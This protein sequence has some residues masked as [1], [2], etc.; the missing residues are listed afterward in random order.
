[1]TDFCNAP[2]LTPVDVALEQLLLKVTPAQETE[3]IALVDACD[4]VLSQDI[5]S[6]VNIPSFDNSAMDG[7]A[8]RSA[9][10]I[11][12]QVLDLVGKVF[13]GH[14]IDQLINQGQCVRIMTGGKIPQGC[15][16]VVM[17]ENTQSL[18]DKIVFTKLPEVGENIRR[19]GEDIKQGQIVLSKGCVLTP[20]DVGLLASLGVVKVEVYKTI[21][22]ALISTGDELQALGEPLQKGQFYESN[23]YTVAALLKRFGVHVFNLGIVKDDLNA[24]RKAFLLADEKADVVITSGGVSVGEADYTKTVIEELGHIDFWKL[25]I[26]PGK[27]FAFGRLPNSYII[28]L[29][30]NPVSALVTLHQ[31]AIPMLRKIS[32]Q[33]TKPALRLHA[34]TSG[35]LRKRPGRMDFQRG[36]FYQNENGSLEV[37]ATGGQGSGILSSMSQAN[38]YIVLAQEAG[39]V[40]AGE[41]VII[42]PFD[43]L[44]K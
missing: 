33:D 29:P 34:V 35:P 12:S 5:K 21:T 13:A 32:G 1:M 18:G 4:R 3:L 8:L 43:E 39:N 30:G 26:K 24:L 31:L 37:K 20:A 9:D 17:Q 6:D 10:L 11:E 41:S 19:A 44:L 36:I 40:A 23:G 22:V 25:A 2:D 16:A 14:P 27:P 42:E 28:G 15:D 7:Y 38:C